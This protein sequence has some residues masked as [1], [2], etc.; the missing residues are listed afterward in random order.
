MASGYLWAKV[1]GTQPMGIHSQ[2]LPPRSCRYL[3]QAQPLFAMLIKLVNFA[4]DD[5]S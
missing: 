3:R 2:T 5:S 4:P 1:V